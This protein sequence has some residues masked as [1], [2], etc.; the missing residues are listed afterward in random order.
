[1]FEP[2]DPRFQEIL[3]LADAA[4]GIG[5]KEEQR[6]RWRTL[7]GELL[8]ELRGKDP[9]YLSQR[10]DLRA[11][12]ELEVH[13]L[14]PEQMASLAT[15]T[16]GAGGLSIAVSEEVPTGTVLE[17]SIQLEEREMPF[18]VKAQ[19][20]WSRPGMLGAAF[21]DL[22]QNDRELMEALT[23]KSL[24]VLSAAG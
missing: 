8:G 11:D 22:F 20:V 1:M 13:I 15:S 19:V 3:L 4:T 18:L 5:L 17:L 23:V 12:A 21:I 16:I 2:E 6:E 10:K 7:C 14:A 9:S 24:L